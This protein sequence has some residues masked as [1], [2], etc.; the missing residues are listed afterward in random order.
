MK[1]PFSLLPT[2]AVIFSLAPSAGA[3]NV[4]VS[5]TAD[6]VNDTT[7]SIAALIGAPGGAGISLREAIIAANNTPGADVITLPAG[8][9]TLTRIGNDATCQNGDLDINDSLTI[10][11]AGSGS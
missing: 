1:I 2:L 10:T 3:A 9:Y 8:I 4:T 5:T 7:V 6:E 11:G